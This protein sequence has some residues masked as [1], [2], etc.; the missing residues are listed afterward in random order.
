M[1]RTILGLCAR[2]HGH[3]V[4]YASLQQSLANYAAAQPAWENLVHE[5][6]RQGIAP[7]LY[8]HISEIG[9]PLP[10]A[11]R[12]MLVALHLR[13]RRASSVRNIAISEIL[14]AFRQE[15][16][17][18]LLVKGI[19]LSH[20]A[21]GSPAYRPMRDIDLLTRKADLAKAER[22]LLDLGYQPDNIHDIPSDYYHLAPL[23]KSIQGLAVSIEVHHNLLPFHADYPLWPFEK[24]SE[25]AQTFYIDQHL[26]Q[27]LNLK[28]S[29]WYIYLHGFRAPLTY[30]EFR[31]IHVADIVNLVEGFHE[32]IKWPELFSEYPALR[33]LLVCINHLT[34]WQEQQAALLEPDGTD[35]PS[36]P[37]SP[38][39]GWPLRR[40]KT[41]RISEMSGLARETLWPS[42][43]WLQLYYG[44]LD[45]PGYLK[46]RF[47]DHP[48]QL[49]RWIKAYWYRFYR[50]L[51]K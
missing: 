4:M 41:V 29:L 31:F 45:G 14:A 8:K 3:Q 46:A 51:G 9:F 1:I 39:R 7:L 13:S 21:Y 2:E 42:Q 18:L 25:T 12:R 16:I 48:R 19:A 10:D 49:W 50:N 34:P 26:A 27:T 23:T 43:W 35:R 33:T 24:S 28:D 40:L 11:I 44:V 15:E 17:E 20:L 38:Y 47:F 36:R 5:A 6:E 37:G 30:E 22:T 32:S